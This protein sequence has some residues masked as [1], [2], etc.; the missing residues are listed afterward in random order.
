MEHTSVDSS[1][2]SGPHYSSQSDPHAGPPLRLYYVVYGALMVLLLLTVAV[3]QFHLGWFGVIVALTIAIVKAV[4][5]VLYFMHLR[6]SS[7]LT[8]VFAGA[9]LVWLLIMIGITFSDYISRGWV[10]Q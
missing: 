3:A 7:R 9:G 1:P 5:V 2:D 10:G 8:W 6:Y 4:L